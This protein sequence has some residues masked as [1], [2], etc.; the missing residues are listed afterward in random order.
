[1]LSTTRIV[2][3]NGALSWR[4]AV[5]GIGSA[6]TVQVNE[7]ES[8][9]ATTTIQQS[10]SGGTSYSLRLRTKDGKNRKLVDNIASRQEARW[11]VAQIEK[12][13]GL[14]LNTQ[15]EISDSI[16]GPPPQPES[17]QTVGF[18]SRSRATRSGNWS[19]TVG[20]IF[21]L[22]WVAFMGFM[23]F[24][25]T[26]INHSR[27]RVAKPAAAAPRFIRTDSMRH[28]SLME[29]QAWP[30]QQRA[31]EL[32]A[33][34][35]GHD[36][37]ALQQL[38]LATPRWTS[39]VHRSDNLERL[40]NQ[41]RYSS[42]LRVRRAEA[43]VELAADGWQKSPQAA[44]LLMQRA[45]SDASYRPAALYFIGI[46]AGDGIETDRGQRFLIDYARN[47]PDATTRQWA[48]EGLQFVGTDETLDELFNVF[49]HDPS[50]AVRDRAG[51]ELSDCGI[52]QRTQRW[53]MVPRLIDLVSDPSL[54][55]QMKNWSFMALREITGENLPAD[56][57]AWKHWYEKNGAAKRVEFAAL[58]WWQVR[59]DN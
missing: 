24:R 49:A 21:F 41:A 34:A 7:V 14:T 51:C 10:G 6:Q 8:I 47:D 32:M 39:A 31:E 11:I 57:S 28:T 56:S 30:V 19:H 58:P 18:P 55:S 1:V 20:A 26:R 2:V 13:A 16:Y 35:V 12:R 33:R 59:G 43:D 5:L 52:F 15:V 22:A 38:V 37:D 46:L 29:L 42:D 4:K 17:F 27:A 3:G 25:T 45:K 9:L 53:K 36:A 50:F 44:N 48:T 54:N 23:I 40:E